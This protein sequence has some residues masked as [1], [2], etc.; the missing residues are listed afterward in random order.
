MEELEEQFENDIEAD[1]WKT[2]VREW[3][4]YFKFGDKT[5][6]TEAE[7]KVAGNSNPSIKSKSK[8][9]KKPKRNDLCPCGSGKKYKHCCGRSR[10]RRRP[11][12]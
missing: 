4:G 8:S 7:Q 1:I 9:T 12:S 11:L 3:R 10:P 2:F 5:S 6:S